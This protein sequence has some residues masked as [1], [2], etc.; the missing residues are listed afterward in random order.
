[1]KR[2]EIIQERTRLEKQLRDYEMQYVSEIVEHIKN[3]ENVKTCISITKVKFSNIIDKPLSPRCYN[4][5]KQIEILLANTKDE[6]K[7]KVLNNVIE[8]LKVDGYP[9]LRKETIEYLK[10]L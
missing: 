4:S 5:A 3:I 2:N 6:Y 9:I 8:T 7:F 10:S 1:M